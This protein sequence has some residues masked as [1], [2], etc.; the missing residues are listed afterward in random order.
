MKSSKKKVIMAVSGGMDSSMAAAALIE[1][2]YDVHGVYLDLW[3]SFSEETEIIDDTR[4][5]LDALSKEFEFPIEIINKKQEFRQ[6]IVDYFIRSLEMGLTPN[7]CVVCNKHIKFKV[8]FEVLKRMN[9]DHIATGHYARIHETRDGHYHLLKGKDSSKDQSYYLAL[10]DQATLSRTLFPLGYLNK[11]D[12]KIAYSNIFRTEKELSESQDL[13][14]LSGKDYRAF[15]E[16]YAPGSLKKGLIVDRVGKV[17]GEHKGLAN[18]TIGQRKGLQIAAREPYYVIEKSIRDNQLIV[19]TQKALGRNSFTV[20]EINWI[21]G[22]PS[23]KTRQYA[24]KIRYR[25]K[26]ILAKVTSLDTTGATVLVQTRKELR[27]ITPGQFAVFYHR[28]RVI[29]GGEISL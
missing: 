18:Y 27:D 26:P 1:A 10:L 6:V 2:G 15:L 14:F 17:L 19:G 5:K 12:I 22:C 7:P 4:D 28:D 9:A 8:L 3:K 24:V 25:A 20:N 29:A 16:R 21:A 13:C 23:S 11:K